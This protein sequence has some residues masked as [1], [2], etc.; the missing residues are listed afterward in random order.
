MNYN[1]I[2]QDRGKRVY[3]SGGGE[4]PHA[5]RARLLERGCTGQRVTKRPFSSLPSGRYF[6][7]D[8]AVP[9]GVDPCALSQFVN[10]KS[11]TVRILGREVEMEN[12]G[13]SRSVLIPHS[14]VWTTHM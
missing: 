6:C 7:G 14:S 12:F 2:D 4:A 5:S 8:L 11:G 1:I 9:A 10:G 13:V 3:V